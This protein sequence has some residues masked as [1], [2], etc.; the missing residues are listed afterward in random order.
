MG[1]STSCKKTGRTIDMGAGGFAALRERVAALESEEWRA[2]YKTLSTPPLLK[3]KAFYDEFN[4]KTEKLLKQKKVHIKV[5]DFC[6][7]TDISGSIRFGACQQILKA[8]G[9]YDDDVLYGYCGRPDCAKFADFKRILQDCVD[10][11]CNM[12]WD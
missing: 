12:I 11:R 2:L 3:N 9:D 8:I 6:L 7:Q 5:V 4:A 1:V 10:N